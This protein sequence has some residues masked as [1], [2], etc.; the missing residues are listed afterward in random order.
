MRTRPAIFCVIALAAAAGACSLFTS[1]DGFTGGTDDANADAN[2]DGASA[3]DG[4]SGGD[5]VARDATPDGPWCA[6]QPPHTFCSDFDEVPLGV[7]WPTIETGSSLTV[8]SSAWTSP[9]NALFLDHPGTGS[10]VANVAKSFPTPGTR[11]HCEFDV[12]FDVVSTADLHLARFYVDSPSFSYY[13]VSLIRTSS[14]LSVDLNAG[15]LPYAKWQ[16]AQAT[17]SGEWSRV[18]LEIGLPGGGDPD[19]GSVQGLIAGGPVGGGT[20]TEQVPTNVTGIDFV[21][22]PAADAPGSGAWSIRFDNVAC[23]VTP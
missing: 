5:V 17:A 8:G 23:D 4:S 16:V 11:L 12:R 18:A 19:A 7:D 10:F 3:L 6:N 22:G 1:L 9:P 15:G 20:R 13:Q 2:A 21:L 14:G